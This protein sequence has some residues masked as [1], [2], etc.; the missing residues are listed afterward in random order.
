MRRKIGSVNI[1]SVVAILCII[2][3]AGAT[4]FLVGQ[5]KQSEIDNLKSQYETER[6][7]YENEISTLNS[8]IAS[9]EKILNEDSQ[10]YVKNM[11]NGLRDYSNGDYYYGGGMAYSI[12]AHDCYDLDSFYIAFLYYLSASQSY[13][14][15]VEN[16]SS[17]KTYFDEAIEN[18]SNNKT[19]RVAEIYSSLSD[20]YAKAFSEL[21]EAY[22]DFSDACWYYDQNDYNTGNFKLE[23]YN[24][25]IETY[26]DL[27][28][29]I[30]GL[31]DDLNT[32]LEN[33]DII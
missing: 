26:N 19:R 22:T 27:I 7:Q 23:L 16:Y 5:I 6:N 32:L 33:F 30:S 21:S 25:H 1:I 18:A 31:E 14:S 8:Q 4:Y 9:L 24:E 15:A 17:A 28:E 12:E 13:D 2:S 3:S 29:P 10:N 11:I 20:T